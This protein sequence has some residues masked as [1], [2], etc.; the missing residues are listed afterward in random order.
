MCEKSKC[1]RKGNYAKLMPII[2]IKGSF[3]ETPLYGE[4]RSDKQDGDNGKGMRRKQSP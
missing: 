2:Y 4:V 1:R 3:Y